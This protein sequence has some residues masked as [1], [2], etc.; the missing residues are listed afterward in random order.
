MSS[1]NIQLYTGL[2]Y[3]LLVEVNSGGGDTDF[4][5]EEDGSLLAH[6]VQRSRT[7]VLFNRDVCPAGL[8]L[9]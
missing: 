8:G 2:S 3:L 4:I 7:R 9:I 1:L 6:N 5:G